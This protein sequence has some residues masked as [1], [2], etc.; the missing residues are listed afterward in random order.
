VFLPP[1]PFG[2]RLEASEL[3]IYIATI[4]F[5]LK[6]RP[7]LDLSHVRVIALLIVFFLIQVVSVA[8]ASA[9]GA[10]N[11]SFDRVDLADLRRAIQLAF[12][13]LLFLNLGKALAYDATLFRG[14]VNKACLIVFLPSFV[15]TAQFFD[16]FGLRDIVVDVYQTVFLMESRELRS[17]Y[18]TASVFQD[19]YTSGIYTVWSILFCLYILLKF[20]GSP[21]VMIIGGCVVS[22][23]SLF[24]TSRTGILAASAGMCILIMSVL[25]LERKLLGR[26]II[27]FGVVISGVCFLVFVIILSD[28]SRFSW[29][30]EVMNIFGANRHEISSLYVTELGNSQTLDF[31]IDRLSVLFVPIHPDASGEDFASGEFLGL[32]LDSFYLNSVIR[33]GMY[34]VGLYFVVLTFVLNVGVRTRNHFLVSMFVL[35]AVIGLKG[36]NGLLLTKVVIPLGFMFAVSSVV[37]AL[38]FSSRARLDC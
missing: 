18:R 35:S 13:F 36:G 5:Y 34:M 26:S 24:Y 19:S 33:Y 29:A 4:L 3:M 1:L 7:V 28:A 20:K 2:N 12:S 16:V 32:F 25:L 31:I 9:S 37:A 8:L 23:I 22:Y 30:L 10:P 15:A 17:A 27:Y 38:P 11:V 14:I 21:K 6:Y